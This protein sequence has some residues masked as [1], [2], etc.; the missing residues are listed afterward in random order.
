MQACVGLAHFW[1]ASKRWRGNDNFLTQEKKIKKM[2]EKLNI[3]S[4]AKN[5]YFFLI[6]VSIFYLK[7]NFGKTKKCQSKNCVC[8]FSKLKKK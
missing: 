3:Y 1:Q 6:G 5:L 4:D 8:E 7:W 2:V